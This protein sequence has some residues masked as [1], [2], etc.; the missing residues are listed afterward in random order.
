MPPEAPVAPTCEVLLG[1]PEMT[2]DAV[3]PLLDGTA[4]DRT[5]ARHALARPLLVLRQRYLQG[6]LVVDGGPHELHWNGRKLLVT[7]ARNGESRGLSAVGEDC[8]D[9]EFY[10]W[11]STPGASLSFHA[12]HPMVVAM[13]GRL[14]VAFDLY[15]HRLT[16]DELERVFGPLRP[17]APEGASAQSFGNK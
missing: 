11:A 8:D 1:G 3:E 14:D 2:L 17:D 16:R 13:T 7:V 9:V 5:S 4:F 10:V 6:E 15:V 12:F